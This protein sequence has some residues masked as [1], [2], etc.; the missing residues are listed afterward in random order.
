MAPLPHV[1]TVAAVPRAPPSAAA[2]SSPR[3]LAV[4]DV[5]SSL[6]SSSGALV[7]AFAAGGDARATVADGGAPAAG[8]GSAIVGGA[9]TVGPCPSSLS[10][11]GVRPP[12]DDMLAVGRAPATLCGPFIPSGVVVGAGSRVRPAAIGDSPVIGANCGLVA[13]GRLQE[14]QC[15]PMVTPYNFAARRDSLVVFPSPEVQL[16]I[17]RDVILRLDLAKQSRKLSV[18][19]V[20]LGEKLAVNIPILL[21]R[22]SGLGSTPALKVKPP[23]VVGRANKVA[24]GSLAHQGR[25]GAH[26]SLRLARRAAGRSSLLVAKALAPDATASWGTS[27]TS[28]TKGKQ[29]ISTHLRQPRHHLKVNRHR[30]NMK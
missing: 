16:E 6:A 24:L 17:A 20:A 1:P 15:C 23:L 8:P 13:V 22:V 7:A 10:A 25:Y 19:E 26:H 30:P 27:S 9:L 14:Q 21:K 2:T 29:V 18:K 12:A 4:V 11:V 28:A 3:A 5:L